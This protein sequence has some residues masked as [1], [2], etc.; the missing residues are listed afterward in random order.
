MCTS[1]VL[2]QQTTSQ[3]DSSSTA[4]AQSGNPFSDVPANS[5]AYQAVK[6]LAADGLVE[7]YPNGKFEGNRPM[8]RYEMAVLVNRAVDKME[9]QIAA[10]QKQNAADIATL[11]KLVDA[12]SAELKAVQDHVA[13]LDTQVQSIAAKQAADEYTMKRAQFHLYTFLRGPGSYQDQ[14]SAYAGPAGISTAAGG[15]ANVPAGGALPPNTRLTSSGNLGSPGG[16]SAANTEYT[17]STTYGTSYMV[18][19]LLFTGDLDPNLSYVFRLENRYYMET[20]G[21]GGANSVSGNSGSAPIY[22]TSLTAQA[23]PLPASATTCPVGSDYP[24]NT[25]FRLNIAQFTWHTPGGFYVAGGRLVEG[26]GGS[27]LGGQ[28]MNLLYSDYF[29]G[30]AIGFAP[31]SGPLASLRIEGGYGVGQPSAQA[32]GS[33]APVG[34]Q[35]QNDFFGQASYDFI[36]HHLN[37]GVA[38]LAENQNGVSLWDPS[39]PILGTAGPLDHH[40]IPGVSGLYCGI[41]YS[42]PTTGCPAFAGTAMDYGS[43]FGTFRMSDYLHVNAEGVMHFGNDPFTGAK[44]QQPYSFWGSVTIG[45]NAG[46]KGTPWAEAGYIASGFNGLSAENGVDSTTAIFPSYINNV[47]GYQV[48]YGGLHYKIANNADI[49]VIAFHSGV[50]GGIAIPASSQACPGCFI[51]GDSRNGIFLQTLFSF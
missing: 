10:G 28:P 30:G 1:P 27:D 25:S 50:L 49:S 44:W 29:N 9:A 45:N 2:A 37:V 47:S 22:C 51:T 40:P 7:G 15:L 38:Y 12:F 46:G 13:A 3:D 24:A 39:A 5:W 34:G 43:V 48:Y 17:G 26:D 8:T 36:P 19:R 6:A 11:K 32:P 14:V 33:S 16:V 42:V 4:V 41:S 20:P 31:T 18:N 35:T 21:Y 23:A